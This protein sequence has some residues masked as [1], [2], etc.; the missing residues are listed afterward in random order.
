MGNGRIYVAGVQAV[1]VSAAQ[2]ILSLLASSTVPLE[3]LNWGVGQTSDFGDANDEGLRLRE[4]RGMT[5]VGSGGTTPSIVPADRLHNRTTATAVC[6]ANDTTAASGGTIDELPEI[7]WNIRSSSWIY[8][9]VPDRTFT[10]DVSTRWAL[11]L[12]AAPLDGI[13]L[14]A[15]VMWRE[16]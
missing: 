1:A 8:M 14:S 13:T 11:N 6:R 10:V 12:P 2:D 5:T 7:G 9:P 3:I 16:L 4:R 15:W